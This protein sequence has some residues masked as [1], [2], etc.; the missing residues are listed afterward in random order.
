MNAIKRLFLF[1][2]AVLWTSAAWAD[3]LPVAED[4][5][6]KIQ[7]LDRLLIT[8]KLHEADP[9]TVT[10]ADKVLSSA[11]RRPLRN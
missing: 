4:L 8:A 9:A 11:H 3:S 10:K 6:Q 7:L 5:S 2:A 1:V